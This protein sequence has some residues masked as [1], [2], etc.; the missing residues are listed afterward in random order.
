M[1]PNIYSLLC[2][3]PL[4]FSSHGPLLCLSVLALRFTDYYGLY[5]YVYR[6]LPSSNTVPR[7]WYRSL[8]GLFP[9][10]PPLYF[11]LCIFISVCVGNSEWN[12]LLPCCCKQ[13]FVKRFIKN[14]FLS[15]SHLL[16]TWFPVWWSFSSATILSSAWRASVSIL[17]SSE[18]VQPFQTKAAFVLHLKEFF[19]LVVLNCQLYF[20]QTVKYRCC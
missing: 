10:L 4:W 5:T 9:S 2:L 14:Q 13:L 20:S 7:V 15:V 1:R 8:R 12:T 19:P 17:Q 6:R 16:F 3:S 18:S 11:W